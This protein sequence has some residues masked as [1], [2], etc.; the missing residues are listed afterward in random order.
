MSTSAEHAIEILSSRPCFTHHMDWE[1]STILQCKNCTLRQEVTGL[2]AYGQIKQSTQYTTIVDSP[3]G[4]CVH[5]HK[6]VK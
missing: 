4:G 3:I 6:V 5:S 2:G 1:T